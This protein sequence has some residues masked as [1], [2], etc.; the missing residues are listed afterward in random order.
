MSTLNTLNLSAPNASETPL[1]AYQPEKPEKQK[2]TA[3]ALVLS[4]A[5]PGTGQIYAG[6]QTAGAVTLAFFWFGVCHH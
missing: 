3:L 1:S 5:M 2:K 4:L 6:R